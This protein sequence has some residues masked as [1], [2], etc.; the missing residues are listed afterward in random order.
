MRYRIIE[1]PCRFEENR[2]TPERTEA[3]WPFGG[4]EPMV[5]GLRIAHFH[6]LE[7]ARRWLAARIKED[8]IHESEMK[9]RINACKEIVHKP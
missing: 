3:W 9:R 7:A 1:S 6:T 5:D 8:R 4:W 2:F